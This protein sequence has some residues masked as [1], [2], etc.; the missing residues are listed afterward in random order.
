MLPILQGT[1]KRRLLVNFRADPQVAQSLIPT[2]L[3]VLEH[4]G[5]AIVGI[6]LIR[7]E[8]IRI[9]GLPQAV[10][11][12]SE[13]M[14]H[15]IAVTYADKDGQ[16]RS[17]VYIWRRDTNQPLNALGGGRLF[18]GAHLPAQF[19]VDDDGLNTELQAKTQQHH[20]DAHVKGQDSI[21]DAFTSQAFA[22]F[23]EA[24]AFFAAGACGFNCTGDG[25][26]LEG[27]ELVT[28]EWLARPVSM[29][30]T[31]SAFYTDEAKWPRGSVEFDCALIMRDIEH[32][33][34]EIRHED[35]PAGN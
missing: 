9:K 25:Q 14:A 26:K 31:D 18:P 33:W 13:N 10:G 12:N 4:R 11:I 29:E 20:A 22:N 8:H 32:E 28:R 27:M 19:D 15:R 2:P 24:R 30:R 35:I 17:A 3:K 21:G 16:D 1:I 34:H 7:L 5:S 6:C 23:E